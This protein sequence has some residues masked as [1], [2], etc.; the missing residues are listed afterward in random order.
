M[1]W[2]IGAGLGWI[3]KPF[4]LPPPRSIAQK[5]KINIF[6]EKEQKERKVRDSKQREGAS[7]L[8]HTAGKQKP[9]KKNFFFQFHPLCIPF[10]CFKKR[11]KCA[12]FKNQNLLPTHP[13]PH[14]PI[15][16]PTPPPCKTKQKQ[17]PGEGKAAAEEKGFRLWQPHRV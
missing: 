1:F 10:Q 2:G 11:E 3:L 14:Q 9:T 17:K 12:N 15:T 7:R 4:P 6:F 13:H 5:G 8:P 16:H